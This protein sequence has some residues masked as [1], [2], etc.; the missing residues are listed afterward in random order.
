MIFQMIIA[1][2]TIMLFAHLYV[3]IGTLFA[4]EK[5]LAWM[6]HFTSVTTFY[7]S[8]STKPGKWSVIYLC[9]RVS[10]FTLSTIF[11]LDCKLFR[12][13]GIC[14]FSIGLWT[15]P[16]VWYFLFFI[17]LWTVPTVWYFSIGLWTVPTVWYLLFFYWIV[18]CS[19]SVVFFL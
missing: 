8:A 18:N 17:G 16:T 13:C 11:L 5:T 15:V 14:C 6:H 19:D 10:I 2:F 12:Q 3:R 4:C 7:W 1:F 9:V